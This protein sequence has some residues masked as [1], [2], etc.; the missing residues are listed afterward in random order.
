[1][2][3]QTYTRLAPYSRK[4]HHQTGASSSTNPTPNRHQT[5]TPSPTPTPPPVQTPSSN[6]NSRHLT[7]SARVQAPSQYPNNNIKTNTKINND[8]ITI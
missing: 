8:V 2:V 1:M 4:N 3:N 7:N 5:G 6:T